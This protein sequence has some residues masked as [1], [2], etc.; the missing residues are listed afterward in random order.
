MTS[1]KWTVLRPTV[2][3][4]PPNSIELAELDDDATLDCMDGGGDDES[5]KSRKIFRAKIEEIFRF[6]ANAVPLVFRL[7]RPLNFL[8]ATIVNGQ[9]RADGRGRAQEKSL[10]VCDLISG[11]ICVPTGTH[12]QLL[13][14]ATL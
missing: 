13:K 6:A 10:R 9:V 11:W 2:H 5:P 7:R 1:S 12:T 8:E 14:G 3:G 4:P